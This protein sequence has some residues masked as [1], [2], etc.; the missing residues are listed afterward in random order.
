VRVL[1]WHFCRPIFHAA[2]FS[3]STFSLVLPLQRFGPFVTRRLGIH[4]TGGS[5]GSKAKT[6]EHQDHSDQGDQGDQ[7]DQEPEPPEHLEHTRTPE[8]YR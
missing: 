7:D 4:D 3:Y 2:P 1:S 5:E 6:P 8:T